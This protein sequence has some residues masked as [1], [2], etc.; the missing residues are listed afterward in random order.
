MTP[1]G[2]LDKGAIELLLQ[3]RRACLI[4]V[5]VHAEQ[6]ITAYDNAPVNAPHTQ[7]SQA[8][9]FE[10]ALAPQPDALTAG[11]CPLSALTKSTELLAARLGA[12]TAA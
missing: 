5:Q 6:K 8:Q 12:D 2:A 4:L 1:R 10:R 9:A 11:A 7:P 3:V